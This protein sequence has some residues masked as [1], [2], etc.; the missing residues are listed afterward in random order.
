MHTKV[1]N[2]IYKLKTN[3]NLKSKQIKQHKNVYKIEEVNLT[4]LK[5]F[6]S[7]NG[8]DGKNINLAFYPIIQR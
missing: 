5:E 3:N 8:V 1:L 4:S 6:H 7:K 2:K